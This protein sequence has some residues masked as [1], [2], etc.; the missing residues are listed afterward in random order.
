[1]DLSQLID[2]S[3][4]SSQTNMMGGVCLHL[5][6]PS[7]GVPNKMLLFRRNHSAGAALEPMAASPRYL[8][9]RAK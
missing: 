4:T 9:K 2:S 3:L 8:P 5:Q 6:S 1:L 7:A